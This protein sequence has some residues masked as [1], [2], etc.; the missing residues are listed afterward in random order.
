MSVVVSIHHSLKRGPPIAIWGGVGD[1]HT[2]YDILMIQKQ[3]RTF[4]LVLEVGH[5]DMKELIIRT[6]HV[7]HSI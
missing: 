5:D 7:M 1:T 6:T 4:Y 2:M 3:I